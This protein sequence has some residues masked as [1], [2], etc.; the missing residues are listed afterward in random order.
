M[1]GGIIEPVIELTGKTTDFYPQSLP[2]SN[3]KQ[4]LQFDASGNGI[5]RG[6]VLTDEGTFRCNFAN[7]NYLVSIGTC[8]FT[9]GSK[10]VT[11]TDFSNPLFD[12]KTGDYIKLD[13]DPN[14][15]FAQ[16]HKFIDL[17]E[18]ELVSP[19]TGTSSTG[20]SSRSLLK[21]IT[22][23]GASFTVASGKG[24]LSAG[25]TANSVSVVGRNVDVP[26][27]VNR[28][29]IRVSQR[30]INQTINIA[31]NDES[32]PVKWFARF[33]LDGTVNT[34]VK[35]QTARNPTSA[36][37]AA[38]TQETIVTIPNGLTTATS[39][40]L[41]Y[42]V[43]LLTESV[44][45]FIN[46]ILVAKHT[47]V[48]PS[49]YDLM[50]CG[51]AVING[52]IAPASN[53]DIEIDYITCKNHNKVEVGV[54]SANESIITQ[55]PFLQS[56]TFNQVGVIAI[57]TDLM[58]IDCSQ[59]SS[60]LIQCTSMGT[61]GV[62]TVQWTNDPALT[63]GNRVTAT[64]FD[65]AGASSTT[66]NSAV[67]RK[68]NR[69]ARYCIIRLTTATTAGTTTLFVNGS[70]LGLQTF[71][72]T[73][74]ISG[75]VTANLGTGGT[76]AT[77]LG[78]AEDA[79]HASGDTGVPAWG[80]RYE[81]LTAPNAAGDYGFIQVDELNKLVITP[82]APSV[83][84]VQGINAAAI[85]TTSDTLIIAAG[86]AGVRNFI[87]SANWVNT[88]A[89]PTEVQIKDGATI[90]WRGW[91]AANSNLYV[92]FPTPLRG[93]AA[94]AVNATCVTTATNT[95]CTLTGFRAL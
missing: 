83:N 64:L 54:M 27:L 67:L 77:S 15:A 80:V 76:S 88:S 65:Q 23:T 37:N 28:K 34:T 7:T 87:T 45:F 52:G 30:I 1:V 95:F 29:L 84:Q 79:A 81:T 53:T 51:V 85:T 75:T 50:S 63:V 32:S 94:T 4:K 6:A 56:F 11:G 5:V 47:K 70:Q 8:T 21:V 60:L 41:E 82:Y 24:T 57:N 3:D 31:F 66:F 71:L 92:Q 18:I 19:Y 20:A 38:E 49:Q 59:F 26:P 40:G 73:Q 68:T 43:E 2:V 17:T 42:K 91:L 69:E 62:V 74:P 13:S 33:Q 44:N 16:I 58:V 25:T 35:C 55:Q 14:T 36:P 46:D 72:A 12:L 78:K 48:I 93:T 89:T 9:N 39:G 22:G 90:I 10:T 61:S 86:A